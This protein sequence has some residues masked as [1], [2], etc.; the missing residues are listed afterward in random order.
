MNG[1][2]EETEQ[3]HV[4]AMG[5]SLGPI[6]HALCKEVVW[7][8]AKWLEYRKLYAKPGKRIDLLNRT[9]A[10]F[11]RVIQDVLWDDVLL[12]IARLTDTPKLGKFE[13]L[14]LRR[15]PD[16]VEDDALATELR[17]LVKT[18]IDRSQ[19][20][21]K[22][23]NKRLAHIDFSHATDVK[24]TTLPGGSRQNV[25]DVLDSF[26]Q[27][28]NRLHLKYFQGEVAFEGFLAH[29]DAEA[30]LY[31]LAFAARCEDRR[32][33]RLRQDNLLPEDLDP[34]PEI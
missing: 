17:E 7:L 12:H 26:R 31:H 28:M 14:T 4:Q 18:G 24:T 33:E 8:H 27:I 34:L 13:N 32:R 29:D 19:F 9:A 23:R 5:K 3:E 22:W 1:P 25:E 11:F 15:L 21:R 16:A 30:L 20:A 2:S 6:Y 10:F